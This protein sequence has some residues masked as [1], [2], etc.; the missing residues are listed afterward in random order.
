[1]KNPA[2]KGRK[3]IGV[4]N[5]ARTH[6]PQNDNPPF[7]RTYLIFDGTMKFFTSWRAVLFLPNQYH[8]YQY[9]WKR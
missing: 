9:A 7:N 6:Y 4:T 8:H 3:F 5:G 2:C 1:M